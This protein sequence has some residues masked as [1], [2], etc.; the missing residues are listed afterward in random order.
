MKQAIMNKI[1]NGQ[2]KMRPKVFFTVGTALLISGTLLAFSFA[3]FMINFISFWIRT[4]FFQADFGPQR[5]FPLFFIKH[6]PWGVLLVSITLVIVGINLL[7]KYELSYRKNLLFLAAGI[8]VAVILSGMVLDITG[9][10]ERLE[11][12][13]QLKNFYKR[14]RICDTSP[15]QNCIQK[16]NERKPPLPLY[17]PYR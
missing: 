16:F 12:K 9:I 8:I 10:N 14:M 4:S 7:T 13:P 15:P 5:P 3:S 1:R 17:Q 11:K 6:F 2:I